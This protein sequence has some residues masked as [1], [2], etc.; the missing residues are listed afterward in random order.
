[1]FFFEHHIKVIIM[2]FLRNH[3]TATFISPLENSHFFKDFAKKAQKYVNARKNVKNVKNR[4]K[5]KKVVKKRPRCVGIY[6]RG[7]AMRCR[8]AEM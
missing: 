8:S 3:L 7:E 2:H 6:S 1:M 4:E 5:I